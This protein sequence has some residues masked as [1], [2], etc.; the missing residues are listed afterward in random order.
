MNWKQLLSKNYHFQSVP[1]AE[2]NSRSIFQADYDRIVFSQYFRYLQ[3]KTQVIPVPEHQFVHNRLT[4]SLEVSSVGRSLGRLAGEYIINKEGLE[5][6]TQEDFGWIVS[7]ACLAHDIGNPAFGH[8]GEAAF[9]EYFNS[10]QLTFLQKELSEEQWN[11]LLLFEGNANGFHLLCNAIGALPGGSKLTFATLGTFV[12]YPR[13]SF[14]IEHKSKWASEKKYGVFQ[15]DEDLFLEVAE[16]IGLIK[17]R[18]DKKCSFFRHPLNFLVEAADDICYCIIDFE[19][20]TR[21]GWINFETTEK[22]FLNVLKGRYYEK[23]YLEIQNQEEKISY[24]RAQIINVLVNEVIEVYKEKLDLIM[25]GE[26]DEPLL[27]YVPSGAEFETIRS[28]SFENIYKHELVLEKEVLG[29]QVISFLLASFLSP[30][31]H[32]LKG[33]SSHEAKVF[34]R[35]LPKEISINEMT[36]YDYLIRVCEFVSTLTDRRAINLYRKLKGMKEL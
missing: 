24:L 19:D 32:K 4:H 27:N 7:A 29:Y 15:C 9:T 13:S 36:T 30:L 22:L 2:N 6:V 35:L 31:V 28:V 25:K 18:A 16:N 34:E 26:F 21:L 23:R 10:G 5:N 8:S 20:A 11:D 33:T 1:T 3:D 14:H 12:K 17:N